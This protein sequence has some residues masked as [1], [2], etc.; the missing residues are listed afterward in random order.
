VNKYRFTLNPN[1]QQITIPIDLSWENAGRGE[2]VS[3]YES[4][5]ISQVINPIDDFEVTRFAHS[6]WNIENTK[7]NINYEFFFFDAQDNQNA[8][9]YIVGTSSISFSDVTFNLINGAQAGNIFWYVPYDITFTLTTTT[10]IYGG[11]ISGTGAINLTNDVS[12]NVNGNLL[13]KGTAVTFAGSSVTATIN[14]TIVCYLKGSLILTE[15]GYVA[16]ED[17]N[18]GDK[19]VTKGKIHQSNYIIKA[20]TSLEPVVWIGGFKAP[21]LNSESLPICIKANALGENKPFEDLYVSPAHRILLN[22]KMVLPKDLINGTTI[23][24]DWSRTSVEYYH[25]E[26]DSHYAIVANGILSETYQDDKNLRVI[27]ENTQQS[28]VVPNA[29]P[30]LA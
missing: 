13:A 5:I 27:F 1:T 11:F 21:N 24:Q 30:I 18:V 12:Y 26:L 14:P 4:D 22:G 16:I 8:Q 20:K 7:T 15:N 2:A 28:L 6:F 17:I 3:A 23:Y 9:F 10:A 19:V 25:L 29:Q